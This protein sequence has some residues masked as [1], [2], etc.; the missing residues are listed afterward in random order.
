V[1]F[2]SELKPRPAA[3]G[4]WTLSLDKKTITFN[5]AKTKWSDGTPVSSQDFLRGLQR[6]LS[7]ATVSK[8]AQPLIDLIVG[9]RDFK[10]QKQKSFSQ[11]GVRAPDDQTLILTLNRP[12]PYI[13]SLLALPIAFP[14]REPFKLKPGRP[15][16]GP[17]VIQEAKPGSKLLL[18][19]NASFHKPPKND[20]LFLAVAD[21]NSAL[22]LFE[23]GHLDVVEKIPPSEF[24]RFENSSKLKSAPF[25]ATY[26]LGFNILKA[27]FND[28]SLRR[29]IGA[30]LDRDR[31]KIILQ[32]K[33]SPASAWIPAPLTGSTGSYGMAFDPQKA[34]Q[35][36]KQMPTPP[37]SIELTLDAQLKN[38]LVGQW[39]QSEIKKHLGIEV[40]LKTMEWNAY[41]KY[42]SAERPSF[43]RFAWLAAFP[44]PLSHLN[45]F[46]SGDP[47]NYTGFSN[48]RYDQ[49][50]DQISINTS[51]AER[52]ERIND[53]QKIL[54]ND[55]VA[56]IPLFHYAQNI[57]ISDKW[58]NL[59]LTPMG[60]IR[61]DQARQEP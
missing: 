39:I 5:L 55:E 23:K 34:R 37:K 38:T 4:S 53:A 48:S 33:Q 59:E 44:D 6:T 19:P 31:L 11:V 16:N 32:D 52:A 3:A 26:Y 13:L 60:L 15:T 54:L 36:L 50:V 18:K 8:L 22:A 58:K 21:A 47:N 14:Q 41:L 35:L 49:L 1:T 17:F 10:E 27:P 20:L 57:L 45:V 56:I 51:A 24:K 42:L 28:V 12:A 40:V 25:L 29:A 7:P 30:A 43:F 2:D 61:L 46:K 9:A